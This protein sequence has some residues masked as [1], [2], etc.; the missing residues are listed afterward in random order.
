MSISKLFIMMVSNRIQ[1][2]VNQ[3]MLASVERNISRLRSNC[4]L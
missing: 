2:V 3:I 4:R 1:C